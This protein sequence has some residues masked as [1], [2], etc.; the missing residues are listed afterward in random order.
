MGI[1]FADV[2][3][4]VEGVPALVKAQVRHQPT[5]IAGRGGYSLVLSSH[6]VSV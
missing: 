4:M 6:A 2:D 5:A 1:D 3:H